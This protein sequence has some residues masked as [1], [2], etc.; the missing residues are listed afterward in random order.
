MLRQSDITAAFR[1][2]VLRSSKGFQYLH[3]RDF[4]TALRR[5]G[6]HFSEVEAYDLGFTSTAYSGGDGADGILILEEFA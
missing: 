5:R 1:E 6:I 3:T 2:S 4:V